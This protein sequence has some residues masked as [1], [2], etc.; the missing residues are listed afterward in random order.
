MYVLAY[1]AHFRIA[2]PVDGLIF[3]GSQDRA[4]GAGCLGRA[5]GGNHG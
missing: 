3:Q 4:H 2:P 5:N 1:L